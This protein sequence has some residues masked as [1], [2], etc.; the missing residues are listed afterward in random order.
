MTNDIDERYPAF[1]ERKMTD[2]V[3]RLQCGVCN[4]FTEI[5]R[6]EEAKLLS[7]I[8]PNYPAQRGIVDCK[9]G[10]YQFSLTPHGTHTRA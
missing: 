5:T 6:E 9:C 1:R 8:D 3:I 7:R 4:E 10:R 2:V